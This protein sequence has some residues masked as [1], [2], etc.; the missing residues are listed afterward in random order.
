[1]RILVVGRTFYPHLFPRAF[2]TTELARELVTQGHSVTV[3]VPIED[4]RTRTFCESEGIN[5]IDLGT[6]K[7]P[8]VSIKGSGIFKLTRRAIRRVGSLLFAY[9]EIEVAFQIKSRLKDLANF[10]LAITIA[11]PHAVH[12]GFCS[13]ISSNEKL[14]R[15]WIADCGDPYMGVTIDT[16]GRMFYFKYLEKS[17]CRRADFITVPIN[18]AIEAYYPEFHHKIHVI[19]QGFKFPPP[20]S[21]P[22]FQPNSIPTFAIVGTFIPGVRDP[23]PLLKHLAELKAPFKFICYTKQIDLLKPFQET[24]GDRLECREYIPREQLLCELSKMDFLINLENRTERQS[25]S[26]LIDY[27][28]TK[29]PI[30]TLDAFNLDISKLERF[31]QQDFSARFVVKDLDSYNIERVA[32]QFIT[33]AASKLGHDEI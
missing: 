18:G 6:P 15:V 33:L 26:K 23:R 10:D 17:F 5:L 22:S 29:R 12:W 20:D 8:E 31:F 11:A 13:L 2:R 7:W 4:E 14:C 21:W 19:P 30:L 9:P 25:P 3:S 32:K 1:M 27:A 28:L 24:L 16:F